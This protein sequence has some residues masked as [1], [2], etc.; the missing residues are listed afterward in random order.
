MTFRV[1]Q[2]QKTA[3]EAKAAEYGFDSVGAYI[4]FVCMNAELVATVVIP[5]EIFEPDT[6]D[7]KEIK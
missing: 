3:I 2:N 4:K 1:N 5:D 6:L 7:T